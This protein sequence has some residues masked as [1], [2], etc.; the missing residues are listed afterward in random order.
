MANHRQAYLIALIMSVGSVYLSVEL[1]DW[2]WFSRSG[3]LLVVIGILL[4]SNEIFEH[5]RRLRQR[6]HIED[7]RLNRGFSNGSGSDHDWA[8]DNDMKGLILSRYR[9]ENAWL[10]E[11]HGLYL[12]VIGTLIWG[13]GDLL[14]RLG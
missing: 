6:R 8:N 13:F 1:K 2:T 14:G 7:V 4:T 3:S 5:G 11:S 12:L 9:E 10:G